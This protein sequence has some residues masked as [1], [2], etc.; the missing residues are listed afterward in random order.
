VQELGGEHCPSSGATHGVVGQAYELVVEEV[1]VA[2]AA[3]AD[4]CKVPY[5]V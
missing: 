4:T 1:V 3:D 2:E 5:S